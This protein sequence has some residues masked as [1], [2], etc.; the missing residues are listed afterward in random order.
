[1]P[2]TREADDVGS[3]VSA[4][5][6]TVQ[7][8]ERAGQATT[9][10]LPPTG[11]LVEL[12]DGVLNKGVVADAELSLGIANRELVRV[13]LR[14]LAVTACHAALPPQGEVVGR[15]LDKEETT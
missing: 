14:L 7:A 2:D 15:R 3:A 6:P 13:S 4:E 12:L 8:T 5:A 1:M 9:G 10:T 11:R